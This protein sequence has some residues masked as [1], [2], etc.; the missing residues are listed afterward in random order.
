[1]KIIVSFPEREIYNKFVKKIIKFSEKG[2]LLE[3]LL[4]GIEIPV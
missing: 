3:K 4:A 1:M 2:R